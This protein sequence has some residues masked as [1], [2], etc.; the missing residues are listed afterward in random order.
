MEEMDAPIEP[1]VNLETTEEQ[2][3]IAAKAFLLSSTTT[4]G[5][6]L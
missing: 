4:Y 1:I 2:D 3:I 6:N 5:T